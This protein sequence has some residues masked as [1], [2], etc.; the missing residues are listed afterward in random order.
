MRSLPPRPM[1]RV[2]LTPAEL[3]MLIRAIERDAEAAEQKGQVAAADHLAWRAAACVRCHDGARREH[4]QIE[5]F[6]AF[7]AELCGD[8]RRR[9]RQLLMLLTRWLPDGRIRGHEIR[10]QDS[11]QSRPSPRILQHQNTHRTMGRLRQQC[12]R[13]VE[14][15][16]CAYLFGLRQVEA[17]RRLGN[18]LRVR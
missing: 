9:L 6:S 11:V 16:L 17:A 7:D 3:H 8:Q 1:L 14:I 5:G 18:R 12:A 13:R 2:S 10:R 4:C 15:S